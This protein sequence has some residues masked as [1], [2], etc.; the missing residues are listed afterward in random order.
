M[1]SAGFNI[2]KFDV[3][4][5]C[6]SRCETSLY[7]AI[8]RFG[9]L[10]SSLAISTTAWCSLQSI[11]IWWKRRYVFCCEGKHCAGTECNAEM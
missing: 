10:P 9:V 4:E 11:H 3:K 8:K 1:S 7:F 5:A 6:L 2:T